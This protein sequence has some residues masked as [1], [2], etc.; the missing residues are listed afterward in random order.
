M[1]DWLNHSVTHYYLTPSLNQS[2][3]QCRPHSSTHPVTCTLITYSLRHVV[4]NCS[5]APTNSIT[6]LEIHLIAHCL[7]FPQPLYK[8]LL[9]KLLIDS[10]LYFSFLITFRPNLIILD[11]L[12]VQYFVALTY[13]WGGGGVRLFTDLCTCIS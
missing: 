5:S 2:P 6:N 3:T 1:A 7:N 11:F 8:S 4:T 9:T 10:Q 12:H 13:L